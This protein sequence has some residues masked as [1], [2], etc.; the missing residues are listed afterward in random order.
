MRITRD[1]LLIVVGI[2]LFLSAV[3]A[4]LPYFG[5]IGSEITARG[6]VVQSDCRLSGPV[7][8]SHSPGR[9]NITG[10]WR[11]CQAKVRWDDGRVQTREVLARPLTSDGVPPNTAV[12]ERREDAASRSPLKRSVVYR[13]DFEPKP[14][15]G[16]AALIVVA[17]V[18][19]VIALPPIDRTVQRLRGKS[20][21]IPQARE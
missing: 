18:A 15:W 3:F 6:T 2:L 13:A 14:I 7:T 12:V 10:F 5:Q 1:L 20:P 17:V 19:A 8:K 4:V 9:T 21:N 11:V 16:G